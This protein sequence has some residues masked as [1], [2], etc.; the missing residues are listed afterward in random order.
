MV[1]DVVPETS[2]IFNQLIGLIDGEDTKLQI[3]HLCGATSLSKIYI[4]FGCRHVD[5]KLTTEEKII[6]RQSPD[7]PLDIA[8]PYVYSLVNK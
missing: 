6:A 5:S 2:I 1:T 4:F 7:L 3:L 8:G